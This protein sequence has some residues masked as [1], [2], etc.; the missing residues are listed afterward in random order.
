MTGKKQYNFCLVGAGR[1]GARWVEVISNSADA[2]L[3]LV[4]DR[5]QA[6][7]RALAQKYGAAWAP[8][9]DARLRDKAIDAVL[10]AV[11]HK[12]LFPYARLA[13]LAGKHV[14]VEK[15]GSRTAREMQELI[16]LARRQKRV[17]AIG[18]NYRF[19]DAIAR[20]KKIASSGKIGKINFIR[21]RHGHGGRPGYGQEWRMNKSMAGG[22]VLM[23]QGVHLIDLSHWFLPGG[24]S[25]IS[26][27]RSANFWK[28]AVEDN[29]FVLLKNRQSQIVSLYVGITQWKP[30][31]SLEIFGSRGYCLVEGLGRKYGGREILTVGILS[32]G[33]K[34]RERSVVCNPEP[35]NALR[36]TLSEFL[37]AIKQRRHSVPTGPDA[38][39]VLE[40]VKKAYAASNK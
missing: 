2:R 37:S 4:I 15:P 40:T 16:K 1:M 29:A 21:M 5:D 28:T 27:A 19:Y 17:L 20:A 12:F 8:P 26:A 14:L 33:G 39:L 7:G 32:Q 34:I 25:Q 11:P 35:A 22:G 23:D 6:V 9:L 36:A 24:F 13:L 30:I 10:V 3:G 18:F 31:F 38:L